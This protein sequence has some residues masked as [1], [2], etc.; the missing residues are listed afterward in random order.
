MSAQKFKADLEKFAEVIDVNLAVATRKLA[1]DAWTRIT[2]RTPVDTGR[3][4]ASWDIKE[5]S[6]SDFVPGEDDDEASIDLAKFAGD[7]SGTE[8]V[9]I[10][11]GL[12]YIRYLEDGSSTQAPAGM[13]AITLAELEAEVEFIIK[14]N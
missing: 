4:R 6:P 14:N 10:T 11:S 12:D 3:A 9:F 1:I 5:G 7:I 13:I 8:S 2:E